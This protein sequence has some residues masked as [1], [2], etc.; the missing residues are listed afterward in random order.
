MSNH[1]SRNIIE[2][3]RSGISSRE[4]GHYFSSARPTIM[5]EFHDALEKLSET[6][7]SGGRIISGKYGEGKTH[8]LNTI[9]NMAHQQNMVVS[10]VTLSK[11]TPMSGMHQLYPKILQGT[12]LPGQLQPGI[13]GILEQLS[14]GNPIT[15]SLLDVSR[16]WR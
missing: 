14:P 9:F 2:A 10:T 3:L 6:H 5:R 16:G 8:L 1:Q 13:S 12:Y 15:S 11:E 7:E 4:V